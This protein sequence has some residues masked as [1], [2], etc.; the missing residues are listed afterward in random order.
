MSGSRPQHLQLRHGTYHLRLRVPDDLKALVG[1][2]EVRRSLNAHTLSVARPLALK[3]AAR[4]MET[5]QMLREQ[6][7]TKADARKW[8]EDCFRDLA[9]QAD[10]GFR[11]TS[12]DPDGE[13]RE[14]VGLWEEMAGTIRRQLDNQSFNEPVEPIC[15]SRVTRTGMNWDA[16]PQDIQQD[17]L[18][19]T[20]R[21]L[22]EQQRLFLFRLNEQLLPFKP[23]DPLFAYIGEPQAEQVSRAHVPPVQDQPIG[24]T[25]A[26]V[27]ERYL[28]SGRQLW[29]LKTWVSRRTRLRFL[30]EHLGGDRPIT[31]ITAADIRS[32]GDA[33]V[34]LRNTRSASVSQSFRARQ[35]DN[36]EHRISLK[37]ASLI[38]ATAKSFFQWAESTR[39]YITNNPALKVQIELPKRSKGPKP[40]RSFSPE[41]L[42]TLFNAPIFTGYKSV[43]RRFDPGDEIIK[44]DRYWLPIL[45]YYTGARLG[46][47]V[48]LHL[49]DVVVDCDIPHIRIDEINSG[50]IGSDSF[51]SVK[52]SD[53]VRI[54]PLHPDVMSLG[55]ATFVARVRNEK[56]KCVRLFWRTAHGADG[57]A[58]TVFSKWFARLLDK[59]GLV[60]PRIVFHSFRHHAEDCF[61][62]A[63]VDQSVTNRIIGHKN[64]GTSEQYGDGLWLETSYEAVKS[65]KFRVSLPEILL[66]RRSSEG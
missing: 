54:V 16:I 65:M 4:V 19:G 15:R 5:F 17:L 25:L 58:S 27:V 31:T 21:A 10:R 2:S 1:L 18:T 9:A 46:E 56:R 53:S 40:R 41:E 32:F 8:I 39:G 34:K 29:A 23:A 64:I 52:S 7:L 55:F 63:L 57:Q 20:A 42:I 26:E 36:I 14:A 12:N 66:Q 48:Q 37:T 49:S 50:P 62:N 24:P 30:V 61:R 33:V 51:K 35:T 59:V 22:L 38:F 3:Y 28:T 43:Y 60:D 11:P 47:L 6:N 45:G 44:D 13:L